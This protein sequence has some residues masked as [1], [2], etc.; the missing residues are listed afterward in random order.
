MDQVVTFGMIIT[1]SKP[2]FRDQWFGPMAPAVF[3]VNCRWVRDNGIFFS[4]S[5]GVQRLAAD[6]S[7][8]ARRRSRMI[9]NCMNGSN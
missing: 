5:N 3:V 2:Q 1:N 4:G 7:T 8:L 9:F 6:K